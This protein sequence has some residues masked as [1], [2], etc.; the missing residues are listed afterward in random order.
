MS[1]WMDGNLWCTLYLVKNFSEC[2][3]NAVHAFDHEHCVF[4]DGYFRGKY[5][6][7]FGHVLYSKGTT[8]QSL[9]K[10][11][12]KSMGEGNLMLLYF[13]LDIW[14][15]T[16]MIPNQRSEGLCQKINKMFDI[17]Y[18]CTTAVPL[19]GKSG[20]EMKKEGRWKNV[21]EQQAERWVRREDKRSFDMLWDR[22][23]RSDVD[24]WVR[25]GQIKLKWHF[26]R[27]LRCL[28]LSL[29]LMMCLCVHGLCNSPLCACWCWFMVTV[30]MRVLGSICCMES[31][32]SEH[33]CVCGAQSCQCLTGPV[34]PPELIL[35]TSS[36]LTELGKT[37]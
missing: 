31:L 28:C 14:S 30:N 10:R 18:F 27:F 25:Q 20:T 17:E 11:K 2:W 32:L 16:K 13:H 3:L 7:V 23:D 1:V 29:S 34:K 37:V 26:A 33:T 6:L 9:K 8:V 15:E 35:W 4:E 19:R 5:F 12:K 36:V 21:V 24:S 22:T